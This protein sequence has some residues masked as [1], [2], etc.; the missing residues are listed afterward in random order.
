MLDSARGEPPLDRFPDQAGGVGAVESVDGDDARGRRD[1]DFGEPFAADYVEADE[2]ES[3]AL[4]FGSNSGADFLF[5]RRELRLRGLAADSEVRANLAFAGDPID[6][7]GDLAV[8]ENDPLVALRDFGK[9]F[10][11]DMRFAIRSVE[12]FDQ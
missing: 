4:E 6:R 2:E 8:D 3:A 9:E 10:L 11:N 7:A 1:V 5:A 12:Q